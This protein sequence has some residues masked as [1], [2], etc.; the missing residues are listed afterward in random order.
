MPCE[1]ENNVEPNIFSAV[2]NVKK[3]EVIKG[4][5]GIIACI[6]SAVIISKTIHHL[7]NR[8]LRKTVTL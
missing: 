5:F 4:I 2:F 3:K 7:W 6:I 8:E 1:K